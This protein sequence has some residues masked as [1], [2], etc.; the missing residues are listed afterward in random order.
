MA[1]AFTIFIYMFKVMTSI[2]LFRPRTY[3]TQFR[4]KR[5]KMRICIKYVADVDGIQVM[6][7]PGKLS[8]LKLLQK[9]CCAF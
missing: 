7:L 6:Y 1:K 4:K 8:Q 2:S 9:K 3:L 5:L